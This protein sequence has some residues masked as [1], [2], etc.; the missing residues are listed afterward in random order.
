MTTPKPLALDDVVAHLAGSGLFGLLDLDRLRALAPLFGAVDYGAMQ[1]VTRQGDTDA[2]LWLVADGMLALERAEADGTV[3][4]TRLL[5]YGDA[6]GLRGVFA[7]LPRETTVVVV[8]PALLLYAERDGLWTYF[9]AD[10]EALDLLV[11]PDVIRQ[12]MG[13]SAAEQSVAGEV[14]VATYRRHWIALARGMVLPAVVSLIA[15][16]L[17]LA[18][19]PLASS[20]WGIL[21]LAVVA[22]GLPLAAL[23]WGFVNW[24]MDYLMIT[25][26]R[27]VHVDKLPLVSERRR[28]M[29]LTRVQDIRVSVPNLMARTLG[30]GRVSVQSA[31]TAGDLTFR[32]IARP[33]SV[34]ELVMGQ[35]GQVQD[36]AKR[37]RQ[38]Q[39]DHRIRMALGQVPPGE[40]MAPQAG[41]EAQ[42]LDRS[43]PGPLAFLAVALD[44][45]LPRTRVEVGDVVT[46]RKHWWVLV[47]NSGLWLLVALALALL[48]VGSV[49]GA[50]AL[51]WWLGVPGW[52]IALGLLSWT[53]ANWRND[54]YQLT[55]KHIIDVEQLPLGFRSDR[56][57]ASLSQIQDTRYEVPN[58]WAM[59][60]NYGSVRIQTAAETGDFSFDDVHDPAGVQHE[61]VARIERFRERAQAEIEARQADDFARWLARYHEITG[62]Q[63]PSE[64]AN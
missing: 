52:L 17:V 26:R 37:E 32:P 14:V 5:D 3:R 25:N 12:R 46:W 2:S 4:T 43:R 44:H 18:L 19:A 49:S 54:F 48:W 63:P 39:I 15:L 10:P 22:L 61:I 27:I 13:L 60:L 42:E 64:G 35:V 47:R 24:R 30:Y 58:P 11:L 59:L 33:E 1:T 55:N 53:Y 36:T 57:Q 38:A 21:L 51:P 31:G 8:D 20:T 62:S 9:R 7:G 28:E 29:P 34:R 56:R 6:V 45:L 40:A 16:P 41:G 23:A 50:L